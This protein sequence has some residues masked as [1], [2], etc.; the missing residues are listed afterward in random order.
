MTEHRKH[1][2]WTDER[3]DRLRAIIVDAPAKSTATDIAAY[4]GCGVTRNGIIGV[5]TRENIAM[6]GKGEAGR[7]RRDDVVSAHPK[8][9]RPPAS[10][11]RPSATRDSHKAP[12]V[13]GG[14][15]LVPAPPIRA[16]HFIAIPMSPRVTIVDLNE[17]MCRWPLGD[18]SDF[19]AFR[20]CGCPAP[21]S[22]A[23]CAHHSKIAYQPIQDRRRERDRERRL[24]AG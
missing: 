20:Y 12:T 4:F 14:A 11:P 16:D 2:Y 15:A 22:S 1:L 7:S 17:A 10:S 23:Y 8:P 9:P 5:C 13:S 18:P 24:I 3:L 19:D 21:G 6:P